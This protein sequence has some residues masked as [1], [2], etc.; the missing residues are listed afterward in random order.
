MGGNPAAGII[1]GLLLLSAANTA[2]MAMVSV[3]YSMAQD[4]ELPRVLTRLKEERYPLYCE[5]VCVVG[6]VGA[7]KKGVRYQVK[8][9]NRA[10]SEPEALPRPDELDSPSEWV[11]RVG[12]A[13]ERGLFSLFR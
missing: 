8:D 7:A 5:F 11:D 1:F 3:L 6:N 10:W 2:I 12:A 13:R 9:L 4:S